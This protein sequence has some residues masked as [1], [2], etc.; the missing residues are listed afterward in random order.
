MKQLLC[1]GD[2]NTWGLIPGTLDRYPWETRWTGILQE[3]LTDRDVRVIE[4]GLCGRTTMYEDAR[5]PYRNGL[6]LL[7]LALETHRPVDGAVLMLG[8]NDCKSCYHLT[9]DEIA[10]G[11]E[12][13]VK[14]LMTC[15]PVKRI[16]LVSPI[17]LGEKVWQPGYDPEFN[18]RAVTVS[19]QLGDAYRTV[20]E[21][22]NL[23]YLA[24][25]DYAAPSEKDQEHMTPEGHRALAQAI[26]HE[27]DP[28]FPVW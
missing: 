22:Y 5:R 6:Q 16:L 28:Y 1:Y 12:Q 7:P 23:L 3:L 25:S 24:A 19:R 21:R 14:A 15:I 20:A 18:Q 26:Y 13:C 8:T 27:F 2:S 17:H 9:A 4:E 11:A 10:F